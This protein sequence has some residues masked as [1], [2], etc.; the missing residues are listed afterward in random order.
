MTRA[1][2]RPALLVL[3]SRLH[4]SASNAPKSAGNAKADEASP[5]YT[6]GTYISFGTGM[7]W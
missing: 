4:R 2:I 1:A 6:S 7:R 5:Q 3:R